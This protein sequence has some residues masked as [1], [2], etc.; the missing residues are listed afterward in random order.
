MSRSL[1]APHGIKINALDNN[2]RMRRKLSWS[3]PKVRNAASE[4][5]LTH[6]P[7][8]L[9]EGFLYKP[10]FL[11]IVRKTFNIAAEIHDNNFCFFFSEGWKKEA[12]VCIAHI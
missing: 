3:S 4:G 6:K 9:K 10:G 11:K 12:M 1:H 7:V 2:P 8:I 5:V